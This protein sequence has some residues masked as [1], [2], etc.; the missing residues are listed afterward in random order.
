MAVFTAIKNKAGQLAAGLAGQAIKSTLGLNRAPGLGAT[1]VGSGPVKGTAAGATMQ[2]PLDLGSEENSHFI[3]FTVIKTEGKTQL[4][5]PS[6]D[7]GSVSADNN[8]EFGSISAF[9]GNIND[10]DAIASRAIENSAEIGSGGSSNSLTLNAIPGST[11]SGPFIALYMPPSLTEAYSLRY[12]ETE[13]GPAANIGAGLF[14]AF[15]AEGG[16]LRD[17]IRKALDSEAARKGP[18]TALNKKV[19]SVVDAIA[20]GTAAVVGINRGAVFTPKMELMFEGINRRQFNYTFMMMPS[21]QQEAD[22]ID[23]II[24][25]FKIESSSNFKEDELGMQMEIPNRWRIEYFNGSRGNGYLTKIHD[26]YLETINVTYGGDKQIFH[27]TTSKGAP[28]SRVVMTLNFRE[29]EVVTKQMLQEDVSSSFFGAV[30]S[31]FE[32]LGGPT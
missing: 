9:R 17:Q 24:N 28:P 21:S 12:N 27:E 8:P 11:K 4:K 7:F 3:L 15:K 10:A 25:T 22:E 29:I 1:P 13:I 19:L 32:N 20:P 26:C 18:G 30:S 16:D 31:G 6:K 5:S 2:Y 14:E 23:K